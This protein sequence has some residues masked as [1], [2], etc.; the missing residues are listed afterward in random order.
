MSAKIIQGP[1]SNPLTNVGSSAALDEYPWHVLTPPPGT[2]PKD[3]Q[4]TVKD[5][6]RL[7][8]LGGPSGGKL[9]LPKGWRFDWEKH[10]ELISNLS[11][12]GEDLPDDIA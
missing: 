2:K 4:Q 11:S 6:Q 7:V 8:M 9:M 10:K 3:Y 1:W 12:I 5:L